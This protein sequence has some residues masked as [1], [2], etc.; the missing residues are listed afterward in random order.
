LE[1]GQKVSTIDMVCLTHMGHETIG[2]LPGMILTA[3][4]VVKMATDHA[5]QAAA[6]AGA[7][8][9]LKIQQQQSKKAN[10]KQNNR[11]ESSSLPIQP[12]LKLIGPGGTYKFFRSL[13]H[14]MRRESFF[15]D[16]REGA[17]VQGGS[18][19]SKDNASSQKKK[20]DSGN[21]SPK[22]SSN[23]DNDSF[24]VHSFSAFT[25]TDRYANTD[26]TLDSAV[27]PSKKR[28]RTTENGENCT[29]DT[30]NTPTMPQH[31]FS[32]HQ[33]RDQPHHPYSREILSFLFT[34]PPIQGRFMIEKA[35]ALGVPRGPLY[36]QLKA[37]KTVTFPRSASS[38]CD[39]ET[40]TVTVE[41]H[42]VVEPGSPGVVVAVLCY[43]CLDV[44]D[45]LQNSSEVQ[46]FQRQ[47]LEN[48]IAA[49]DPS[50]SNQKKKK[51]KDCDKKPILEL[52]V[53]ITNQSTFDSDACVTWR[54]S[55]F[56]QSVQHMFLRAETT[57]TSIDNEIATRSLSVFQS[58]HSGAN[59]RSKV[60]ND[61]F[62]D[63]LAEVVDIGNNS[64][65]TTCQEPQ[66]LPDEE[67]KSDEL[68]GAVHA[69]PLLEY[70]LLPRAKRG[71]FN[72]D[73]L[74]TKW[75]AMEEEAQVL[76]DSSGCIDRAE[77]ILEEYSSSSSMAID[78]DTSS[79]N[80]TMGGE[81]LFTGT[82]SAVPCKHRNVSGI[83]VRMDNGNAMLLDI[84]EGTIGQLLR[85][86]Q[87]QDYR[88][89]GEESLADVLKKIKAVWISHPHADHHLGI[90]RLLEERKGL[91]GDRDPLVLIAPP[92]I[93]AFLQEYESVEPRMADSY[94]FL[95]C[96]DIST[97]NNGN[98]D[99]NIGANRVALQ[100]LQQDLGIHSCAAIPVA[101]CAYS[102][103]VVFHGTSFGSLAYSGDC[104]PSKNFAKTAYNADLLIHEA[105][106]ADGM[107]ADAVVK[108]HCTAGEALQV[109]KNMNAK[110][111]ILTHF[112]QRYPKIPMLRAAE[113]TDNA[114]NTGSTTNTTSLS[115]QSSPPGGMPVIHA[116][117]FMTITPSNIPAASKLTPALQMLYLDGSEDSVLNGSAETSDAR[118]ALEVPGLF[119]QSELL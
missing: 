36:G 90:L 24:L 72:H 53:H 12:G 4:D 117:D 26:T 87:R 20:R 57:T 43:P 25:K 2:G 35:K 109:A 58:A 106:F 92:N 66:R 22:N 50:S 37:G 81:I 103:A 33:A 62:R 111:C 69:V 32:H 107:E 63:P 29:S 55:F 84:G 116:F 41:S 93:L 86:K 16:I 48:D 23:P 38:D 51:K 85:A 21:K 39:S 76:L 77:Q 99:A 114:T 83:H 27:L 100:R 94:I 119:A 108:R 45:Q 75:K 78:K 9:S 115:S 40:T 67:A 68:H 5:K 1:F 6:G 46:Q 80:T 31:S 49:A 28:P 47:T 89:N 54:K 52:I 7:V 91:V 10:N 59:L 118:A 61:V 42:Q 88:K 8:G 13:R 73:L 98:N 64:T 14:F 95:D 112:S 105:T 97:N 65:D 3:S 102:F 96:R 30:T 19:D 110:A 60:S 44:L 11:T 113:N 79:N 104:R 74:F 101:H 56:Q 18:S 17:C 70:V 71:F 34:T 15:I 82:G